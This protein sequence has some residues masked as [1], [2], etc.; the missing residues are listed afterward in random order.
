MDKAW[1]TVFIY[2]FFKLFLVGFNVMIGI[3]NPGLGGLFSV[4]GI[5]FPFFFFACICFTTLKITVIF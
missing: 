3:E 1:A 4:G 2:F 5:C